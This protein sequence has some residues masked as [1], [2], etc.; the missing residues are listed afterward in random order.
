VILYEIFDWLDKYFNIDS[1]DLDV[2]YVAFCELHADAFYCSSLVH[3]LFFV[4]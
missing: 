2:F 4:N 3:V 1:F